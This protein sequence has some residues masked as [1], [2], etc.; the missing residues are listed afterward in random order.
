VEI[1]PT[2]PLLACDIDLALVTPQAVFQD[3]DETSEN[4]ESDGVRPSHD[5]LGGSGFC[6]AT[7]L[8]FSSQ[9]RLSS[10]IM[11][12]CTRSLLSAMG[13]KAVTAKLVAGL[14]RSFK[15]FFARPDYLTVRIGRKRR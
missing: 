15:T 8:S 10:F 5:P 7:S 3:G 6:L 4:C 14:V 12:F 13:S 1:P 2:V 11:T 9:C